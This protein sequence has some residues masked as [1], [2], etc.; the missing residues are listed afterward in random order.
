MRCIEKNKCEIEMRNEIEIRSFD[1][2]M[3][4]DVRHKHVRERKPD[5][6]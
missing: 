4:F 2:R 5:G 1:K 3:T 6:Q